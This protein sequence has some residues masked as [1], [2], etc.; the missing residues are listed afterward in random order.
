MKRGS[1][2][3]E[4]SS[5]WQRVPIE[6]L[7]GVV[8]TG[9]AEITND[10][11][12]ELVRR[13]IRIAALS[14]TGRLRFVIGGP[15]GGN[16]HLRVAQHQ[17]AFDVERANDLARTLVAGKLQNCRRMMQR[18]LW[19]AKD[20]SRAVIEEEIRAI[21]EVIQ[22]LALLN[23]GDRVRGAEGDGSRRYFKCLGIHLAA[24]TPAIRFDRR[25]RRPPR[26][27]ANAVLSFVYGLIL[28][29]LIGGLDAVGLDPQVGFLHRPRSGRPSLALDLLEE[30]RSSVADRFSVALLTRK[31]LVDSDFD[32]LGGACYLSAAGRERLLTLWEEYRTEEVPHAILGRPVGMWALPTVQATLMARHVRGDL[33]CY[34]PYLAGG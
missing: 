13:G 11:I 34:P 10:A 12:G 9:R 18:W 5:G 26:D 29:E 7:D 22:S 28:T 32:Q 23:D 6:T 2:T 3:V 30:F 4:Q 31:Q 1:L 25:S 8:L 24:Q 17:L 15:L 20:P 19:D 27:S 16:V 33:P 14:K 21:G